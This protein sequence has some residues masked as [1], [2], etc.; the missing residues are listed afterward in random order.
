MKAECALSLLNQ[1]SEFYS[2]EELVFLNKELSR[3]SY[4]ELYK[5]LK[6]ENDRLE[7]R[8]EDIIRIG[9]KLRNNLPLEDWERE[10]LGF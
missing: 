8:N 7:K 2:K 3:N 6:E 1:N 9:G 5:T 10:L 4:N